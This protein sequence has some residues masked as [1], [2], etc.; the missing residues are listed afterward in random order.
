MVIISIMIYD[1]EDREATDEGDVTRTQTMM[2]LTMIRMS[3]TMVMMLI[4]TMITSNDD[5]DRD[6]GKE[7]ISSYDDN[8]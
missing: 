5:D 6:T 1:E 3:R 2:I 8:V 7:K 4:V